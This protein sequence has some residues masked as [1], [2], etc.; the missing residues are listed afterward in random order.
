M[1]KK[2]VLAGCGNLGKIIAEGIYSQLTEEYELSGVYGQPIETAEAFGKCYGCQVFST[3]EEA[4]ASRPDFVIEAAAAS[5]VWAIAAPAL[6]AGI[7]VILLSVGGL[8]DE[9]NRK[10]LEAIGK[11]NQAKIY[12]ASG[13]I[14][15]FDLMEALKFGG[16]YKAE[17]ETTKN[18]RSLNGAPYLKGK[19]LSED[20]PSVVFE[21]SSREAIEGFP[22]NVNVSVSLALATNGPDAT[23]V[24]IR[25]LPGAC[26][27]HH[28][29]TLKGD[30]GEASVDVNVKPSPNNPKSASL[31]AWS[32]LAMLK[33][34]SETIVL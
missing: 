4:A 30:F 34:F 8:A 17:I 28:H 23:K 13:A 12:V 1:R 16:H 26:T 33:R 20:K 27:N 7:D 32:V 9:D 14:G 29:I 10:K 31:A 18:P 22:Q 11:A 15:G 5:A 2:I 19:T 21:G 24:R 25:S 3:M 6:K